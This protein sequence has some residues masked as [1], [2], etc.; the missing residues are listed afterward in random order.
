MPVFHAL[1]AA[2]LLLPIAAVLAQRAGPP[3]GTLRTLATFAAESPAA[4][5]HVSPDGRFVLLGTSKELLVYEVASRRTRKLADA[6]S[7]DML[8]W[9]AR[10]DRIAWTQAGDDGGT[11]YVWSMPLDPTTAVPTAPAQRVTVGQAWQPAISVDGRWLAYVAPDSSQ[12]G[13]ASASPCSESTA[14]ARLRP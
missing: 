9:S 7:I 5:P 11:N 8:E 6:R 3:P 2:P 13:S 1:L 4:D 14:T 12:A 10:G